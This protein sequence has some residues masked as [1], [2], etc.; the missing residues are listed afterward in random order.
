MT[1]SL[2]Q[3]LTLSYLPS[4]LIEYTLHQPQPLAHLDSQR[5][6]GAVLF[7]DVSGFTELTEQLAQQGEAGVEALT[8][9]INHY[10]GEIIA[11]ITEYGGDILK[12]AGDALVVLWSCPTPAHL[13]EQTAIACHCALQLKQKFHNYE[14]PPDVRLGVRIG[15]SAGEL[16]EA[17]VG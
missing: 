5:F 8:E 4:R 7:I 17:I 16:I 13:A 9:T 2:P 12:F 10:F 11:F 1:P 3:N 14:I 6:L 15:I